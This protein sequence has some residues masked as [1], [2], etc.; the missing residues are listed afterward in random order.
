[1]ARIKSVVLGALLPLTFAL[2]HNT[3]ED[4][5]MK[6][7]YDGLNSAAERT[8]AVIDAFRVSWDGYY[9]YAFPNDEL[10][11]VTNSFSN[12]RNAWGASAVDALSTAIIMEQK[13]IVN[14][15][16]DYIPTINYANT[17]TEVSLFETTIRY[18]GGMISG[19][20]FLTGPLAKLADNK[21]NVDALLKQSQNLAN[22]LSYAFETPTG[23][24]FNGLTLASRGVDGGPN[25]L[26]TTGTLVLEWTRLAD[27]SGNKTYADIV[28]KA[29]SYLLHPQPPESEP[30]PGLVGMDID[31][32]TGKF[33]DARGGWVGG[34]DS[35]YEYLIKMWVYDPNR[36]AEYKDRWIAAADSTI[37]H[38]TSHPKP[39]PE[40]TFLAMYNGRSLS[41][42]SQHLACFD[43]GNFIL[44][45]QVLGNQSYIDYGLKLVDGCH[46]TYTQTAT[47]IG[48]EIFGWDETKVPGGQENFFNK[49]G[50]YITNSGYQL[51][52]EVVESFYYAY[53]VTGD[54]KY[55]DWAWEAFQDINATTRVGSGYSSIDN[56]NVV[57][58]GRKTDFQESFWF[59][60]VLKY[61]YLIHAPEAEWQ[62][63]KGG[64]NKWVFNTEA[65]PFKV[66]GGT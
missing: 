22:V 56:V 64:K 40:L 28:Q 14:T 29:E 57:G 1:M 48:P 38:L 47:G 10:K 61:S 35:F 37:Q 30:W 51:R 7:R 24:P 46:E 66:S 65:H 23:I 18:L 6:R 21:E 42:V 8:Q 25:G 50:F 36:F 17:T 13:D 16:L 4:L 27:L 9:K 15:I 34:A 12:S 20:D 39:R 58:G 3:P 45:G 5:N 59:A 52:P 55:Q 53:R 11:P 60:E 33:L 63:D 32:N 54:S 44:G 2:P 43:G 62:V 49:S 19:Y 26:A 31:V 41:L